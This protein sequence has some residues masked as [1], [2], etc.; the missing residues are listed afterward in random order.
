[1]LLSFES[2]L[3]VKPTRRRLIAFASAIIQDLTVTLISEMTTS[4][5]ELV[6]DDYEKCGVNAKAFSS[7]QEWHL[8]KVVNVWHK[9]V[10]KT[11]HSVTTKYPGFCSAVK[12]SRRPQFFIW[13]I[14]VIM[15]WTASTCI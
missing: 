5:V 12:A 9:V 8:H 6:E 7:E 4:D 14:I 2:L 1:L 11:A 3:S 10:K 15:V 13:N